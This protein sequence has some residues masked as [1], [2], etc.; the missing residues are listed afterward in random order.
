MDFVFTCYYI[1]VKYNLIIDRI[2]DIVLYNLTKNFDIG[3]RYNQQ[4]SVAFC[5]IKLIN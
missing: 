4:Y 1:C 5:I 2:F 3:V